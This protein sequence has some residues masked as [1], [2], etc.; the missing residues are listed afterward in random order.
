MVAMS[1][2][3]KFRLLTPVGVLVAEFV[4]LQSFSYVKEVNAP[5]LLTLDVDSRHPIVGLLDD[6]LDDIIEVWRRDK[7]AGIDWYCDF[8][9]LYRDEMRQADRNGQV[10]VRL[11]FPGPMSLLGRV[12]IAYRGEVNNRTLFTGVPVETI[13]HTLVTYNATAS[14]TTGDGRNRNVD[15]TSVS[16]ESDGAY[17]TAID[18]GAHHRRLLDVLQE[19]TRMAPGDFDMV[20]MGA[21]IWQ[22]R[23]YAEQLGADKSD[24]VRFALQWNNMGEPRYVKNKLNERTVAIVGGQGDEATRKYRITIPSYSNYDAG[25]NSVEYYVDASGTTEDDEI[26]SMGNASIWENRADAQ[27]TFTALDTESTRYGRDYGLGDLVKG[28]FEGISKTLKAYMV[29]VTMDG[30][31]QEQIR[32]E[33][34]NA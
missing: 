4:D 30:S 11:Y 29:T 2:D 12:I 28:Y 34:R 27:L 19:I 23:F 5:G 31:G 1:V 33:V 3:Y 10:T 24:T 9:G 16:V 13:M 20:Y 26:D 15:L 25:S 7:G 8:R 22:Y 21:G 17:G 14:G 18:Y 32:V 6:S